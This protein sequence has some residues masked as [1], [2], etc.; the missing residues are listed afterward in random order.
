MDSNGK[1]KVVHGKEIVRTKRELDNQELDNMIKD[2][3]MEEL[4]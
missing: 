2:I 1:G 3:N 4:P